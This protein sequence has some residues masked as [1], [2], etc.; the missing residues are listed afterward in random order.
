MTI[1]LSCQ[2]QA[3]MHTAALGAYPKECCGLLIGHREFDATGQ[4]V[5]RQVV[6]IYSLE[7]SWNESVQSVTDPELSAD[8]NL[9]Q[10][11]RYWVKP[12]TLLQ[13]QRSCR[14]L[15]LDLIGVYHSHPDHPAVPSECDRRLAWPLYSYIIVSV[16]Q[17]QVVDFRSWRLDDV[18]Q[19]QPEPVKIISTFANKGSNMT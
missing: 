11:R 19:F 14:D 17:G 9:D 4:E 6:E 16:K 12:E 8:A 7:N 2:G 10:H 3:D 1:Y 5:S 15:N 13:V 18:D